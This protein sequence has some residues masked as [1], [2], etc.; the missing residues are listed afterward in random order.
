MRSLTFIGLAAL[1]FL[2]AALNDPN[3]DPEKANARPVERTYT[4][5]LLN[6]P[7]PEGAIPNGNGVYVLTQS[8]IAAIK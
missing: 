1:A 2:A 6:A 7:I 8:Q 4:K 3:D 5:G